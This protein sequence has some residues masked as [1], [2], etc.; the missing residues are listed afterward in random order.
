MNSGPF[1]LLILSKEVTKGSSLA[2]IRIRTKNV[3]SKLEQA[4]NFTVNVAFWFC[5]D[6]FCQKPEGNKRDFS[7]FSVT[8]KT[9]IFVLFQIQKVTFCKRR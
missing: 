2:G 9:I 7:R 5:N 6:D 4:L 3:T 1:G 8:L